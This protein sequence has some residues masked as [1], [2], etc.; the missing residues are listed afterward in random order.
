MGEKNIILY[1]G[2]TIGLFGGLFFWYR[3]V[4]SFFQFGSFIQAGG[5]VVISLICL[6]VFFESLSRIFGWKND[7]VDLNKKQ[8]KKEK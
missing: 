8:I 4:E 2:S 5:A 1:I 3:A 6:G 7:T